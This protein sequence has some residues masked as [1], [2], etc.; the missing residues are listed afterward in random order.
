MHRFSMTA[1]LLTLSIA[2][3]HAQDALTRD[4]RISDLTQ[5]ASQYAKNYVP[6][7]GNAMFKG[8]ICFG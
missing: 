2:T 3:A 5:L 7:S 1:L 4:Q 6:T 8:S